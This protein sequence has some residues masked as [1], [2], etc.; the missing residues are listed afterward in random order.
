MYKNIRL[1]VTKDYEE[2]SQKAAEIVANQVRQ[3]PNCVLG[4]ATGGTPVRMYELLA[5]M[6]KENALD[7][8]GIT[9]FNLDEYH[10]IAPTSDQSYHYYMQQNFYNHVNAKPSNAHIPSGMAK[11]IQ[12]ECERFENAIGSAGGIDLQIL[13]I[14]NNGHIGFNEPAKTFP[15]KTHHVELDEVTIQSNARYFA[16]AS[17]VPRHALTMGIRTIMMAKQIVL[18]AS[19]EAK[20]ETLRASFIGDIT[21]TV[22]ASVLQLHH[23]VAVIADEAAA[24]Y[25]I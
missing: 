10:P 21:P 9:G 14:G 11:D 7:F 17:E 15:A 12:A 1:I 20:A 24:K 3:K 2:M 8:S 25:L 23:N 6:H 16:D 18:L 4:L 13:G 5:T 22:P 19:G